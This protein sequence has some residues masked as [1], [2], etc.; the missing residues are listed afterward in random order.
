MDRVSDGASPVGGALHRDA[1]ALAEVLLHTDD[2]Q[3][4]AQFPLRL[5]RNAIG[6]LSHALRNP[7]VPDDGDEP[8]ICAVPV[9]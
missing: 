4:T 2:D 7:A 6:L 3:S 1:A 9:R 8:P 5:Q